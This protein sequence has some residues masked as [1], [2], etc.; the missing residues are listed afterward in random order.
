MSLHMASSVCKNFML[1]PLTITDLSPY[2]KAPF[3]G[4][5]LI[6]NFEIVTRNGRLTCVLK[7]VVIPEQRCLDEIQHVTQPDVDFPV[8]QEL[9]KEIIKNTTSGSTYIVMDND[10]FKLTSSPYGI[11]ACAGQI[12]VSTS[13]NL[14]RLH[15]HDFLLRVLLEWWQQLQWVLFRAVL[16]RGP[17]VGHGFS[18]PFP[19]GV[20][21]WCLLVVPFLLDLLPL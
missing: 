3:P 7:G 17:L 6:L 16:H 9:K 4:F 2:F 14:K 5:S 13:D 1:T 21:L 8:Q 11:S 20:P 12:A 18:W 10:K 15:D 19:F